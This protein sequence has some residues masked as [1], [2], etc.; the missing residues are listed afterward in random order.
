MLRLLSRLYGAVVARRNARY[1]ARTRP[2][3]TVTVPVVSVGNI[4]A[5]G[6]GKTPFV[7]MIVKKLQEQ[8]KHP[9]VVLRGYRRSSKGLLV[10]HDGA[11]IVASVE[12]A[13]D[14]AYLHATMLGVP[15][16]VSEDKVEAAAIAAGTLPCD[17]IVV[18]DGFQHRALHR[19]VDIVLVDRATINGS[20]LPAGRLRE[21]LTSL[22]R[23]DVVV[24]MGN[25]SEEDVLQYTNPD[26]IIV[27]CSIESSS[28]LALGARLIAI[29]GIAHPQ[30]FFDGLQ[31]AGYT[32]VDKIIFRDHHKYNQR[33]VNRMCLLAEQL[34]ASI[35]TTEKDFVKLKPLMFVNG[36][37]RIPTS[38]VSIQ[39]RLSSS[40][41]D[42][43]I[44]QRTRS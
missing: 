11:G 12:Q 15:V 23:A 41:F 17:V 2:I 8:G 24:C 14:E 43:L 42:Q 25:V 38:V 18:D 22:R 5:G 13:G 27:S 19:D 21:P 1:D 34:N 20:L 36:S 10:V 28:P 26:A 6:T 37:T 4:S 33:D 30:R 3:V 39:A 35:V 44:V 40:D 29:A 7:Q 31:Q 9:A 32:V 16:V